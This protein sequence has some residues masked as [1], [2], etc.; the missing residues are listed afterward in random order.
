MESE[1]EPTPP[2]TP[3]KKKSKKK[4]RPTKKE[5]KAKSKKTFKEGDKYRPGMEWDTAWPKDTKFAFKK[6]RWEW[7]RANP[8]EEKADRIKSMKEMLAHEEAR[9][10]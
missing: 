6:A 8:K 2:P 3:V 5:K 9:Q 10:V 7:Q 4:A 1:E